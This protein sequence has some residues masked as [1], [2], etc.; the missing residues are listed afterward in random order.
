M[1]ALP[2]FNMF[3]YEKLLFMLVNSEYIYV[4]FFVLTL[5][6]ICWGIIFFV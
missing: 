1:G 2:N 5:V 4:L 6:C 3:L